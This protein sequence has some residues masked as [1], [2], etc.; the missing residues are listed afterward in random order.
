MYLGN[1]EIPAVR[2][3]DQPFRILAYPARDYGEYYDR[4]TTERMTLARMRNKLRKKWEIGFLEKRFF[5]WYNILGRNDTSTECRLP[6]LKYANC[7]CIFPKV[8]V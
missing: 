4:N 2:G 8:M 5:L 1:K 3:R 6:R 7:I